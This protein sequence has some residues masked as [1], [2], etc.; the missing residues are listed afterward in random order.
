MPD[1]RVQRLWEDPAN[2]TTIGLYRCADDPRWWVPKR[3]PWMG[4]TVNVAHRGAV[5][6]LF[7]ILILGTM[8]PLLL[9]YT[10]APSRS[11]ALVALT[12]GIPIVMSL[13]LVIWLA[14]RDS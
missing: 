9:V 11:P 8:P 12:V 4:W 7:G 1:E 10:P 14:T 2:W 6:V 5:L 13:G 3:V